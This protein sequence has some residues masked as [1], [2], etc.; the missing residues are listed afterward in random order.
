M[1]SRLLRC[2]IAFLMLTA[3][4]APIRAIAATDVRPRAV[5]PLVI[6]DLN[7]QV[8][9]TRAI[10]SSF[11]FASVNCLAGTTSFPTIASIAG[12]I[13]LYP[14]RW[15][16]TRTLLCRPRA[17]LDAYTFTISGTA[18][19]GDAE[20]IDGV[21]VARCSFGANVTFR[22][23]LELGTQ[24]DDF[25]RLQVSEPFRFPVTCGFLISSASQAFTVTGS[26]AGVAVVDGSGS[27]CVKS[28][29]ACARFTLSGAGAT[30]TSASGRYAG[31]VAVGTFDHSD[32]L[33]IP[34]LVQLSYLLDTVRIADVAAAA[35]A[36]VE[37]PDIPP[38][39]SSMR[40]EFLSGTTLSSLLRPVLPY[41]RRLPRVPLGGDVSVSTAPGTVCRM[42][43]S[44]DG[45][46]VLLGN[47]TATSLGLAT[48]LIS[49]RVRERVAIGL[50]DRSGAIQAT[51]TAV[52]TTIDT[53][54]VMTRRI[55]FE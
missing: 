32:I 4:N 18:T 22:M 38:T 52:C 37:I 6:S 3:V 10:S 14:E 36:P 39:L 54:A 30:V 7:M 29:R 15:N 41:E 53:R 46:R 19:S 11:R 49:A 21:V 2:V 34:E 26:I 25:V 16:Q 48:W 24:V 17:E 43:M 20:L 35:V 51:V 1:T 5:S 13:R 31:L 40:L 47:R 45:K 9:L 12:S 50:A 55:V 27:S 8:D 28:I 33:Q 44:N 42:Y 23:K